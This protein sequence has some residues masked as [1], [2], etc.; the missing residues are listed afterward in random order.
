[1]LKTINS[2]GTVAIDTNVYLTGGALVGY[3]TGAQTFMRD[4]NKIR[5]II[6]QATRFEL[7]NGANASGTESIAMGNTANAR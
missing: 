7:G 5:P 3:T 2:D 4:G 6:T 1:L